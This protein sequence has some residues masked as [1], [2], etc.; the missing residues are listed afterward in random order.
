MSEDR[1]LRLDRLPF[2][3]SLAPHHGCGPGQVL[4]PR[5]NTSGGRNASY[6]QPMR[7]GRTLLEVLLERSFGGVRRPAVFVQLRPPRSA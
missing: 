2:R 6:T 3:L 5:A 4:S 7:Q 1:C